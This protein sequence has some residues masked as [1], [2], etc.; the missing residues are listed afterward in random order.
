MNKLEKEL[1]VRLEPGASG[2]GDARFAEVWGAVRY[3]IDEPYKPAAEVTAEFGKRADGGFYGRIS[4]LG[5][6][7]FVLEEDFMTRFS[8]LFEGL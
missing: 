1:V 4:S 3:F 2:A 8:R 7:V 6:G 5:Q